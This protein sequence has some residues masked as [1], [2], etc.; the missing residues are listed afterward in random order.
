MVLSTSNLV[1]TEKDH[2]KRYTATIRAGVILRMRRELR[3][4]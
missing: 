2:G 4:L 1:E 3:G